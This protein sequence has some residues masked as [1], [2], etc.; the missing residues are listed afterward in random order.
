MTTTPPNKVTGPSAGGPRKRS[1][2]SKVRIAEG[3]VA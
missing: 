3:L 2:A 1:A